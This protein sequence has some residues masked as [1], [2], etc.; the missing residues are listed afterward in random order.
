MKNQKRT[1]L[2]LLLDVNDINER[3][4]KFINDTD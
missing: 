1:D 4:K 2:N 3:A